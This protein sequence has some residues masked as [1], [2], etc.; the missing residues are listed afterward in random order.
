MCKRLL[1]LSFFLIIFLHNTYAQTSASVFDR[2][3]IK[4]G[5][6]QSSV[7]F[8]IQDKYGFLW[9]ATNGG[10]N[11][12]DGYSFTIYQHDG[13]DSTSISHNEI[14]YLFEDNKGF[15]WVIN[16]GN[17]GLDK[18]DPATEKFI[19]YSNDPSDVTSISS[20]NI[21]HVMQ[22]KHGNIWICADNA[23][24]LV[25]EKK[26]NNKTITTFQRYSTKTKKPFKYA[27]E[28]RNKQLLLF[29]D[30]LY[31]FNRET[32]VF[33]KS[34]VELVESDINSLIEDKSGNILLGTFNS[35]IIKLAYNA[36]TSTYERVD[37]GKINLTPTNRTVL[38]NDI[39]DRLWIATE[40]NGLS[41][42]DK[43]NDQW[44]NYMPD[45]LDD[46]SISDNNIYSLLIDHSGILWIGTFS[47]GLCKYDLYK[48]EFEHFKSV[49][50]NANS[51]G[52]NVITSIHSINSKELWV[53]LDLDGGV[54]RI[55]FNEKNEPDFIHYKHDPDNNNSI[56]ANNTLCLVQRRNGEVWIGS[57]IGTISKI[58]PKNPKT[59]ENEVIKRYPIGRWT[60]S[61]FEDSEGV[62]WGGTW[63]GGLWRFNDDTEEFTFFT[64]EQDNPLSLCDNIVWAIGEDAYK[65]IWIGGH[66]NGLSI[67][68]AQEK[69]KSN[70]QFINFEYKKADTLSLSNNTINAFCKSNSGTMWI[71]TIGGLNKVIDKDNSLKNLNKNSKLEFV[72]YHKKD[73]L[74][75]ES[76]LGIVEDKNKNL[77]LSTSNGISKFNVADTIFTNYYESDGLQSN[78]FRHNAYFINTEGKIFFG[79]QNGFNAFYPDR[80]KPNAIL[81]T[82]VLTD[83]KI[84]NKSINIGQI[85]DN[86]V[87]ISKPIY[88]TSSIVL[89]YKSN[90]ITFEF[91][92]LHY[93]MPS[94]NQYAY[95]LEGFDN[96]WN[97]VENKRT[98]T[99]TNLEPGEYI[100]RVKASNSDGIWNE[101][102]TSIKIEIIPPWWKTIWFRILL[103]VSI[104]GLI[105]AF[106]KWRTTQ[107]KQNQKLLELKVKEAND[108]VE[109][110][111]MKLAAKEKLSTIMNDVRE[112]LGKASEEL[113]DATNNQLST[114]EEISAS[115]EQMATEVNQNA[116][117][118]IEIFEKAKTVQHNSDK[119]VQTISDA[120]GIIGSIT[121]KI[122]FIS[123]IARSTNLLSLNASIEAARA[124]EQG[125]GFA[126][127]ASEVK[128]LS[129]SSQLTAGEIVG[130]SDSGQKLSKEAGVKINELH[131]FINNFVEIIQKISESSQNQS[132][133][134][135][136]INESILQMSMYITKTSE[137]AS[138]LD[139]AINSLT[140]DD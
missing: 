51:P 49:P 77:W 137:L 24:N 66:G 13:N 135:N 48:K 38:F 25:V 103:I 98:A 115:V 8:I 78:E 116:K 99:Y 80:I 3:T 108:M 55:I 39:Y 75:S 36:T 67:L 110:Q 22:D 31:Y 130:L 64:H 41:R 92:A 70:P 69:H 20:N 95:Y 18:F 71:V 81:P 122:T 21:K 82:V 114:V 7:K 124:G 88:E 87:I 132:D 111:N 46:K 32:K 63:E 127:V 89:S 125:R 102:G 131:G 1:I 27:Y 34:D 72:S 45:K 128:K 83:F 121:N 44:I 73:G 57:A 14:N 136:N 134:A 126:V 138:K 107:L 68:P 129:D 100:F 101:E 74:P 37:A 85:V 47:Q 76:I 61:I 96:G 62:L 93:T 40:T 91:S 52:G 84:D 133:E 4:D 50:F 106:I 53:A 109:I 2:I 12:Y 56:A 43:E 15:I 26:E 105:V 97:Y 19:R 113:M 94:K 59:N 65:N 29:S 33:Q 6:S 58:I 10:L 30:S 17:A 28:N 112:N 104:I 120:V 60:F 9:F 90:I 11:K 118:V 123:E 79:G 16:N 117:S 119:S 35:G 23:L 86:Q 139:A 54:D 5:L 42:Y 140:I